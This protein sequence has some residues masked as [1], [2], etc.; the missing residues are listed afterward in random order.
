MSSWRQTAQL[1]KQTQQRLLPWT[2]ILALLS[3]KVCKALR[4]WLLEIMQNEQTLFPQ[5]LRWEET[6]YP[7][8]QLRSVYRM[9][10]AFTLLGGI[11]EGW[12]LKAE[13]E[14]RLPF[15]S[16]QEVIYL[17][18]KGVKDYLLNLPNWLQ[19]SWRADFIVIILHYS[20]SKRMKEA[21]EAER[22]KLAV[23]WHIYSSD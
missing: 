8:A 3:Q 17:K 9:A 21:L 16:T 20:P 18:P 22:W 11:A 12:F 7:P 15:F 23:P 4:V 2:S 13:K 14:A 6:C 5:S 10:V 19:T 1:C